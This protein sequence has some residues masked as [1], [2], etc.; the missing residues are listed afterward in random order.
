[1]KRVILILALMTTSLQIFSAE[2]TT[3]T[4]EKG[5]HVQHELSSGVVRFGSHTQAQISE[6]GAVTLTQGL[7]L[8]SS[9]SGLFRASTVKVS[10][11]K[12]EISVR[13]TAIIA[14]HADG[15]IKITC[16]EGQVKET[17]RGEKQTLSAG[18]IIQHRADGKSII[19]QVELGPLMQSCALLA[20]DLPELPRAEFLTR[21][22]ETQTKAL[23]QTAAFDTRLIAGGQ[24][25]DQSNTNGASN[26]V[27]LNNV[28]DASPGL[29]AANAV[30]GSFHYNGSSSGSI[31]TGAVIS[32]GS[33]DSGVSF[34]SSTQN[35]SISTT[36]SFQ[37]YGGLIKSGSATAII[38]PTMG[39]VFRIYDN[40]GTQ[41]SVNGTNL[42]VPVTDLSISVSP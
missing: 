11:P 41:T 26:I 16:L 31:S 13:G 5:A 21:A 6:S 4:T 2:V 29:N 42:I 32:L 33:S 30:I 39:D 19:A 25:P 9:E 35:G 22:A 27:A 34:S 36:S 3:V 37:L 14:M 23:K 40:V 15:S 20:A 1:M 8:I 18:M 24:T 17:Y 28:I 7:A 10:T 12:G 38:N